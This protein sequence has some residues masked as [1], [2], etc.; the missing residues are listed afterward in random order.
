MSETPTPARNISHALKLATEIRKQVDRD[1]EKGILYAAKYILQHATKEPE[2]TV[3]TLPKAKAIVLQF[4]QHLLDKNQFEAAA[5][6]Q[7]GADVYDWRPRSAQD[8]WR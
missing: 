3:I 6:I 1:E 7:W 2:N 5:T 8:T 4:V